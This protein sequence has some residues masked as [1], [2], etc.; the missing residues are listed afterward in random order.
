MIS[1]ERNSQRQHKGTHDDVKLS[2]FRIFA[3]QVPQL[4]I[5]YAVFFVNYASNGQ[6]NSYLSFRPHFI[7]QNFRAKTSAVAGKNS[8]RQTYTQTLRNMIYI[9]CPRRFCYLHCILYKYHYKCH[10]TRAYGPHRSR[11]SIMQLDTRCISNLMISN[12]R[13]VFLHK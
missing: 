3:F 6:Q 10:C 9:G 11:P 13:F 8:N 2:S 1:K 7:M 4:C 12:V 5:D